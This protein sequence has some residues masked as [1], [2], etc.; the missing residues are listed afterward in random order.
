M[1]VLNTLLLA[2]CGGCT[3]SVRVECLLLSNRTAGIRH[4]NS[5][6][7]KSTAKVKFQLCLRSLIYCDIESRPVCA[8]G[9]V[10]SILYES[11]ALGLV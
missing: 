5:L 7:F 8:M 6:F 3:E 10:G 9:T 11:A 1:R 2:L 4:E